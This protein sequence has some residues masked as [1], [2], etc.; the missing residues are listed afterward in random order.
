MKTENRILSG[1]TVSAVALTLCCVLA[2]NVFAQLPPEETLAGLKAGPGLEVTLFAAEPDLRNPTSI[3][4][5]ARGRVWV[6][7]AANYRL[8]RQ[9]M[10]DEQGDRIRLLE[11]TDGDGR[12]D[13][14]TTF[15]QDESLQ[16]PLSIAVLGNRV[17]VCQ[18]PDIFYLEDTD[19]DGVADK[20]TVVLTGFRGVDHDHAIHGL[21]FGPDGHLYMSNGDEGLDV[22]DKSG[23][24]TLVANDGPYQAA[25]VLRMDPDGN[26]LELLAHGLRNP[27]EPAVDPFGT[28]FISDNDDDGNEMCRIDYIMEGG[29][30]GYY[31]YRRGDQRL[32]AVHWNEDQPGVVPKMLKTGFGSPSG[33]LYY[34]GDLLP[35]RWQNTLL[36]AD[37]GPAE[38]RSYPIV[39]NGAGFQSSID[40]LLS[41]PDDRWFRPIDVTTAPD[42]SVFVADWYDPGVG[43]HAMGDFERGRIYRLAPPRSTYSVP[44]LDLDSDAGL[45]AAFESPNNARRYLAY[46]ALA[47]KVGEGDTGLLEAIYLEGDRDIKARALWLLSKDEDNGRDLVMEHTRHEDVDFRVQAVRIL[48]SQ[49]MDALKRAPH[50]VTDTSPAVR[51]QLLLEL[52]GEEASWAREWQ[53]KL[54]L[55][56]DG[57]DRFYREA[58]GI[59]LHGHEAEAFQEIVRER[60][61]TWDRTLA[62][63][64][65]QLHPEDAFE[66][67]VDALGNRDLSI[68]QRQ[69]ALKT[70]DAIGS[71]ASGRVLMGQLA[72]DST[73]ALA[74]Y[75][76]HLLARDEGG[77]WEDKLDNE[78]FDDALE[79]ALQDDVIKDYVVA[80]IREVRRTSFIPTMIEV[81][82]DTARSEDERFG[83]LDV[84]EALSSRV[85]GGESED[86]VEGILPLIDDDEAFVQ[87]RALRTVS[88]FHNDSSRATLMAIFLDAD[89]PRALRDDAARY[90]SRTI[91]GSMRFIEMAR[92][93][94]LP[95][96]MVLSV[97]ELLHESLYGEVRTMAGQVLPRQTTSEGEAL[98]P[99]KELLAMRG[100][101]AAGKKV[102]FSE[103]RSQCYQCHVVQDEGRNVGPNLSKIGEK[104][105]RE[106][107]LEAIMNPSAAISDEYKVWV[108]E[109]RG[110]D[111]LTGYIRNETDY[112]LEM[113]DQAGNDVR[114]WRGRITER[115][116][117]AL[118]LMPDG[119]TSG[120]SA[121]ELVALLD[122]LLTLK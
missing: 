101:P 44:P 14:A 70:I 110:G 35:K 89:R 50:L 117:S 71:E 61:S 91:R 81:A 55:Q 17:Y 90:L 121:E 52:A 40:V 34:S 37:A 122:Y 82:K 100:D 105:G 54:A 75:A 56:F 58:V 29:K 69:R 104:L 95:V 15:Y 4:I 67:A 88:T 96:D 80:F 45:R 94:E 41:S 26:R 77:A 43:G 120:M 92:V 36:H 11:D 20:K 93:D 116:E 57:V 42:G 10:E 39:K 107:L 119:L 60:G 109:T 97:T 86:L 84:I 74:Q 111:H 72:P 33:M 113:M 112:S 31:P 118:S 53:L 19:G 28:V 13:K 98:P 76:L 25:S 49:G 63:L 38:I 46:T 9:T 114:V 3:D 30:Y 51:R 6:T 79:A 18:S 12:C 83:A 66:I 7:E 64:A 8:F 1:W 99:L 23:N 85:D 21:I 2:T 78:S 24:R 68:E 48:A 62:E 27:Y 59:G 22:T 73:P 16:A 106:G 32:D 87:A 47:E 5:D 102:F 103:E 108:V 65:I 115:Y